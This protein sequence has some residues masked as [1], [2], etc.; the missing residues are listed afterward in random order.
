MAVNTLSISKKLTKT[1]EERMILANG[2]L[3]N[4]FA[5]IQS[6]L[7]SLSTTFRNSTAFKKGE[8]QVHVYSEHHGY[9]SIHTYSKTVVKCTATVKN[10][11][12]VDMEFVR[13][14]LGGNQYVG[15]SVYTND[16]QSRAK[17]LSHFLGID[18]EYAYRS[19]NDKDLAFRDFVDKMNNYLVRPIK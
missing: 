3:K 12:I 17:H 15:D 4:G 16:V 1:A 14:S 18:L 9:S 13:V 7:D 5:D 11:K 10:G 8:Y 6:V 19:D 2:K